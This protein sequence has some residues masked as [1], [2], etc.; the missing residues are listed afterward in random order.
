MKLFSKKWEREFLLNPA[1]TDFNSSL[2][3][4]LFVHDVPTL[5]DSSLGFTRSRDI[6]KGRLN[7][8]ADFYEPSRMRENALGCLSDL[9]IA[10]SSLLHCMFLSCDHICDPDRR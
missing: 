8:R 10:T 9:H 6:I 5:D 3:K 4:S 2:P 1:S 7:N